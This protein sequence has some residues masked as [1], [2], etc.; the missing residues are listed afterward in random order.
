[1]ADL[2]N[3]GEVAPPLVS[4]KTDARANGPI[5][6]AGTSQPPVS[7]TTTVTT[8]KTK[9]VGGDR[10]QEIARQAKALRDER[11]ATLDA[12]HEYLF[13]RLA[14]AIGIEPPQVEDHVL[15]DEKFDCIDDFFLAGGRRVLMFY[16]QESK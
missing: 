15:G 5:G 9:I 8:T 12:R 7:T 13:G 4:T 2:P 3:G 1:M 16:Y 14:E 11:R 10:Q 6:S